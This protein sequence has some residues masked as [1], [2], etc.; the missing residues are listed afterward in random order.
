[1]KPPAIEGFVKAPIY[2]PGFTPPIELAI[3]GFIHG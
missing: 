1:V 3:Y 2:T